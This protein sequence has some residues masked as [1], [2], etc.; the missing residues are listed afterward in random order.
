MYEEIKVFDRK[1]CTAKDIQFFKSLS[2]LMGE[3]TT[4]VSERNFH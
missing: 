3:V 2:I 4:P 1:S